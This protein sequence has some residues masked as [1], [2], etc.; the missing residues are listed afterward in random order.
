V[1]GTENQKA[2][3]DSECVV[4]AQVD[5]VIESKADIECVVFAQV[6]LVIESKGDNRTVVGLD[7]EVELVK[8]VPQAVAVVR[9]GVVAQELTAGYVHQMY[10]QSFW[11]QL[12]LLKLSPHCF[13]SGL[14]KMA[15]F[16]Q[17]EA[18]PTLSGSQQVLA[19]LLESVQICGPAVGNMK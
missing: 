10:C 11:N 12:P 9:L 8:G 4:F 13:G 3:I 6:D 19:C 17:A 18:W 1:F 16:V 14:K 2:D 15:L 5:L 7:S